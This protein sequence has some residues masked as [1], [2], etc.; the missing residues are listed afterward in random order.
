[1]EKVSDITIKWHSGLRLPASVSERADRRAVEHRHL[2]EQPGLTHSLERELPEQSWETYDSSEFSREKVVFQRARCS[3]FPVEMRGMCE[4]TTY[5][6]VLISITFPLMDR[7]ILE[8]DAAMDVSGSSMIR[9]PISFP[10]FQPS[11]FADKQ[12]HLQHRRSPG[13][14]HGL[15]LRL[16]L[17]GSGGVVG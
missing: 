3:H 12:V 1:M 15:L 8:E 5:V 10:S 16:S 11:T 9:V 2:C 17:R 7:Q 14:S 4:N 6:P 13:S